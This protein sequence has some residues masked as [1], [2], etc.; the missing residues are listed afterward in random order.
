MDEIMNEFSFIEKYLKPLTMGRGEAL[1]LQDDAA[2]FK[3]PSGYELVVSSDTLGAGTH[4]LKDEKPAFVAHKALRV[5]LSDLAAMG[6]KPYAYQLCLTLPHAPQEKMIKDFCAALLK[7]QKE[8]GIFCSGGDTTAV[9]NSFIISITAMGLVPKGKAVKRSGAKAGD[10]IVLT[11]VVGNALAGLRMLQNKLPKEKS[12]IEAYRKPTPRVAVVE[13]IRRYAHAAVDISDGLVADVGHIARAANCAA[14][15]DA[16]KIKFSKPVQSFIDKGKMTFIDAI[17]GG[18]D[19]ELA[20]A[21]SPKNLKALMAQLK[22][23]NLKPQIIG[24]FGK[25]KPGVQVIGHDK[26][27]MDISKSGWT[28]F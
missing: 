9:K 4:F 11:G 12:C 16:D 26:K 22:G 23:K 18:D 10:V 3:I 21:V 27:P 24:S 5:N 17:T 25:G 6:A 8:F 28:H 13:I 1:G 2:I 20:L 19:Y 14:N 15:I 7:D